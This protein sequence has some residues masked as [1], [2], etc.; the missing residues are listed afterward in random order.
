[1]YGF[2]PLEESRY[3]VIRSWASP[4]E[5]WKVNFQIRRILSWTTEREEEVFA[6]IATKCGCALFML[7]FFKEYLQNEKES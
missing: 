4:K 7:E 5:A 3:K 2:T 1:M 6:R